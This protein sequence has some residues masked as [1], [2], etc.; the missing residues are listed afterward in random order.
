MTVEN[1]YD[2]NLWFIEAE[3]QKLDEEIRKRVWERI[4]TPEKLQNLLFKEHGAFGK[5]V[6][7]LML[8]AFGGQQT[9]PGVFVNS[10]FIRQFETR[11][12]KNE[13]TGEFFVFF[14]KNEFCPNTFIGGAVDGN[15]AACRT[16]WKTIILTLGY[17]LMGFEDSDISGRAAYNTEVFIE[18]NGGSQPTDRTDLVKR[19]KVGCVSLTPSEGFDL[20]VS[21]GTKEHVNQALSAFLEL[22]IPAAVHH[23]GD[24]VCVNDGAR[25]MGWDFDEE[26]FLT[27][28]HV[29]DKMTKFVNRSALGISPVAYSE[30]LEPSM[31]HMATSTSKGSVGTMGIRVKIRVV[32]TSV[33]NLGSGGAAVPVEGYDFSVGS[34]RVVRTATLQSRARNNREAQITEIMNELVV[35]SKVPCGSYIASQRVMVD[36]KEVLRPVENL[37]WD[38]E[39]TTLVVEKYEVEPAG[40]GSNDVKVSIIGSWRAKSVGEKLKVDGGKMRTV[41]AEVITRDADGNDLPEYTG[42]TAGDECNKGAQLYYVIWAHSDKEFFQGKPLVMAP[43]Q[44]LSKEYQDRF[45]WWLEQNTR[46]EWI[47][48]RKNRKHYVHFKAMFDGHADWRF[49][50]ETQEVMHLTTVLYGE[51]VTPIEYTTTYENDG[52]SQAYPELIMAMER[53]SPRLAAYYWGQGNKLRQAYRDLFACYAGSEADQEIVLVD[54]ETSLDDLS[55]YD[56]DD[57]L[58]WQFKPEMLHGQSTRAIMQTLAKRFP[59]G[60]K[61][62]VNNRQVIS[63]DFNALSKVDNYV[64][65]G[66]SVGPANEVAMLF[67][68]LASDVTTRDEQG[69]TSFLT[70]R[71]NLYT[72]ELRGLFENAGACKRPMRSG[73]L[74][75]RKVATSDARWVDTWTM[76]LNPNDPLITSGKVKVGDHYGVG[77]MP[78]ISFGMFKVETHEHVAL[79]TFLV[80]PFSWAACNEGDADGDGG[81]F[82]HIPEEM[83]EEVRNALKTKIFGPKGYSAVYTKLPYDDFMKV[84]PSKASVPVKGNEMFWDGKLFIWYGSKIN[85]KDLVELH[86]NVSHHYTANVGTGYQVAAYL[87]YWVSRNSTQAR[88]LSKE[89]VASQELACVWAWRV[90]YEKLGLGGY[91]PKEITLPDGTKVRVFEAFWK[92]LDLLARKYMRAVVFSKEAGCYVA[93]AAQ[94]E[95]LLDAFVEQVDRIS[96]VADLKPLDRT[97]AG[98]ILRAR[99][100]GMMGALLEKGNSLDASLI[101]ERKLAA[102]FLLIRRASKGLLASDKNKDNALSSNHCAVDILN[103]MYRKPEGDTNRFPLDIV[104]LKHGFYATMLQSAFDLHTNAVAAVKAERQDRQARKNRGEE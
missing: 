15:V 36:G 13:E 82:F 89:A 57:K 93:N 22:R 88:N 73:L 101:G 43:G 99:A 23:Q 84:S 24:Y 55:L 90:L 50:D 38:V 21:N 67:T 75:T 85:P 100:L 17:I 76:Y 86:A 53:V 103:R 39:N 3:G 14:D 94:R 87:L 7:E 63:F 59:N 27:A 92:N 80:D 60:C 70:S 6:L 10:G 104:N 81:F 46:K 79:G 45:T 48:M 4:L 96:G 19:N 61:M 11:I 18:G 44:A 33:V 20:Y 54:H 16:P 68:A 34:A 35:C 5:G 58:V 42:I 98:Y 31:Y 97:T 77:R 28:M 26:G 83:V 78:M 71:V 52:K 51:M 91:D 66:K 2:K 37:R 102:E 49:D 9:A 64:T 25:A 56:E 72:R 47:G 95:A 74:Y 40:N 30:L 62:L 32:N 12:E 69:F 65:G 41:M 1:V 29:A 8:K